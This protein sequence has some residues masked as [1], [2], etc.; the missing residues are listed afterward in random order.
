M[1]NT[2]CCTIFYYKSQSQ[3]KVSKMFIIVLLL[4]VLIDF[5]PSV[6]DI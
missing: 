6:E 3:L 4:P 2:K 5:H 1:H